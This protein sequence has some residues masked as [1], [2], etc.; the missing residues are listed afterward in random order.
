MR[1]PVPGQWI[2]NISMEE[3]K[4]EYILSYGP[5]SVVSTGVE[6]RVGDGSKDTNLFDVKLKHR[7]RVWS[8]LQFT[9]SSVYQSNRTF[10]N[11]NQETVH[12]AKK[13]RGRKLATVQLRMG[14]GGKR[15]S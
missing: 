11:A 4:P 1:V 9:Y 13:E 14:D 6:K 15:G 8:N 12:I 3:S 2:E 7:L 5:W 10:P